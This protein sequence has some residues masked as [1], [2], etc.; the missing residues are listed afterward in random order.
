MLYSCG[1]CVVAAWTKHVEELSLKLDLDENE[2]VG[3]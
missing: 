1:V 2:L 3:W